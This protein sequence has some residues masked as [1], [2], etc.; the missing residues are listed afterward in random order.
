MSFKKTYLF[1]A[2]KYYVTC[3]LLLRNLSPNQSLSN[4]V[5]LPFIL[6]LHLVFVYIQDFGL[7]R[8]VRLFFPV[9]RRRPFRVSDVASARNATGSTSFQYWEA[10]SKLSLILDKE[11]FAG[12]R[13]CK[14]LVEVIEGRVKSAIE[15]SWR[16]PEK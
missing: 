7:L 14:K 4:I 3:I 12:G 2:L 16:K 5:F 9:S 15:E 10:I 8:V 6:F 11:P 13:V 1:I